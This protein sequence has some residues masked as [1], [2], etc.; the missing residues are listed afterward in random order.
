MDIDNIL[1]G[2]LDDLADLPEFKPF[3][4][5]AHRVL[6]SMELKKIGDSPVVEL[7]LTMQE[8]LELGEPMAEEDMPK[9]GDTANTLFFMDNEIG[10]GKFK[11]T[12]KVL[13]EGLGM[14]ENSNREIIEAVTDVECVVH[15]SVRQDKKDK[16]KYYLDL[17]ELKIV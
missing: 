12:A 15:T 7:T 4:P 17:K 6:A 11:A 3:P 14:E 1:D 10:V 2:T 16:D 9:A 13:A 8:V 5:G